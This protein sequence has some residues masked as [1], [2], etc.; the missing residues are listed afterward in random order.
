MFYRSGCVLKSFDNRFV[1]S[2]EDQGLSSPLVNTNAKIWMNFWQDFFK[3]VWFHCEIQGTENHN[4]GISGGLVD[5]IG[6]V[7]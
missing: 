3:Q 1:Y 4:D 7:S 5:L 2:S 6:S